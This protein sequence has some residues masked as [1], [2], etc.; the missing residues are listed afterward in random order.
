MWIITKIKLKKSKSTDYI[1]DRWIYDML[2]MFGPQSWTDG[3][4]I[5]FIDGNQRLLDWQT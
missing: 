1:A 2:T 4:Y 5:T 3:T